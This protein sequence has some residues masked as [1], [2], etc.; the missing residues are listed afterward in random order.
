MLFA[1][2]RVAADSLGVVVETTTMRNCKTVESTS[3]T[4]RPDLALEAWELAA[5]A[6]AYL[7]VRSAIKN[8]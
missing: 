6:I 8:Q 3:N 5:L 2:Y 1:V 7:A 4:G